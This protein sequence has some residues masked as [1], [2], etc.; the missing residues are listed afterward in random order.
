MKLLDRLRTSL[1]RLA[2]LVVL[3]VI[4]AGTASAP[5]AL[6]ATQPECPNEAVRQ[7]SNLNPNTSVPY[8]A[9]LPECRAYEMVTPSYMEGDDALFRGISSDGLSVL[10]SSTG[11]F[12]GASNEFPAPNGVMYEILRTPTGWQA[13]PLNPPTTQ[14]SGS[15]DVF[16]ETSDFNKDLFL[17]HTPAQAVDAGSFYIREPPEADGLC[18]AIATTVGDA[19]FVE[20]GPALSPSLTEGPPNRSNAEIEG[21]ADVVYR[22]GSEN[23]SRI[24]FG[25]E[26]DSGV[27]GWPGDTTVGQRSLY[28]YVGTD[29]A[30]P[31]LVGVSNTGKLARNTEASL[32]STCGTGLGDESTTE[33]P[34]VYNA[35]SRS[36]EAVF[37]T[38]EERG[39]CSAAKGPTVRE[40]YARIGG[41]ET[42][43]LSEPLLPGGTSGECA[44]GEPCDGATL[45]EGVFQGASENGELVFFLSE[46]PLVNGAAATGVKLY[47]E[48]LEGGR[49]VEALD[50]S[51]QGSNAGTDPEVQGVARVSE[52]G[53]CVY[54]VAKAVLTG[55]PDLSLAAD[56]QTAAAGEDNLYVYQRDSAYPSGHLSFVATLS[57]EDKNDWRQEDE[58]PMQATTDGEFVVFQSTADLTPGD[59]S[60]VTQIFEYDA[61]TGELARIS[62]GQCPEAETTCAAGE[63]FDDDGNTNTNA[64]ELNA[65]DFVVYSSASGS[66][67]PNG[68]A[69]EGG[70]RSGLAVTEDG[71]QVFFTS[72][73]DLAPSAAA[74]AVDVYEYH[75]HERV[76]ANGNVYAI[77]DGQQ[78][79]AEH[80]GPAEFMGIDASGNNAFI[81]TPVQL[82]GQDT[83]TQSDVYDARIDGGF[84]APAAPPVEC[85]GEACQ[86]ALGAAP[87]LPAAQS[88]GTPSV[89]NLASS[90]F[91]FPTEAAKHNP[92]PL[93]KAQELS[94]ALTQCKRDKTKKK[95]ESCDKRA[96][97]KYGA[98]SKPKGKRNK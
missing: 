66:A 56:D 10:T 35:V 6:A 12:A 60:T 58:R 8:S 88:A 54:F 22:G 47:E 81:Q 76:L 72:A 75:W 5:S 24:V 19:C 20:V 16:D 71:S 67:D 29:D 53:S 91:V 38:A 83:N 15:A 42:V 79:M 78:G 94:K 40:L 93:T 50:V 11:I 92:K 21:D 31:A 27:F 2:L 90:P 13:S 73:D 74:N 52:N 1:G 33:K 43:A 62:I 46:Q 63:R 36:G 68:N 14:F 80:S 95:R 17:L 87:P 84:P 26:S 70:E 9:G 7:E 69:T 3:S 44:V 48:R 30:E 4:A 96:R 55:E 51:G 64:S 18:P 57:P 77:A 41:E 37:F 89:G 25:V 98:K 85:S 65:P 49:V 97:T 86:G 59:T 39:T 32:I 34:D 45:K 82:V 61:R 28:E 23:L